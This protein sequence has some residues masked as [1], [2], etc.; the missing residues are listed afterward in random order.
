MHLTGSRTGSDVINIENRL[1]KVLTVSDHLWTNA[2][3]ADIESWP[4]FWQIK[5]RGRIKNQSA[6]VKPERDTEGI[7]R[8]FWPQTVVKVWK[9]PLWNLICEFLVISSSVLD[10]RRCLLSADSEKVG[11]DIVGSIPA[12]SCSSPTTA[13]EKSSPPRAWS[14]RNAYGVKGGRDC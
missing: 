13:P 2:K 12:S 8:W 11:P 5:V 14:G 1:F 4:I 3:L 6:T 7:N 9:Y 10:Y